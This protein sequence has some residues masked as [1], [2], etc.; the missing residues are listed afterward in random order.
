MN[1]TRAYVDASGNYVRE[2]PGTRTTVTVDDQMVK[3]ATSE[4][5][6]E[7]FLKRM[8]HLRNQEKRAPLGDSHGAWQKV[9]ELPMSWF[10]NQ[11][12]T[13]AWEDKKAVAKIV[14]DSSNR[15]FRADGSHRRI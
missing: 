11:L 12:P 9:A 13:H 7:E 10:M 8:A 4:Y 15:A 5:V 14:N 3:W 1:E 2:R 6:S